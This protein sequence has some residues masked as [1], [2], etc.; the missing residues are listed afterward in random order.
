MKATSC[1]IGPNDD[2]VLPRGSQ[3]TDWEVEL[4]VVIGKP[5]KY[6]D[7]GG[8]AVARRRLL[9]HQRRLRARVSARGHGAVGEGQERRHVRPDRSVARHRRRGRRLRNLDL[10]LEVDGHR[11]QNGSTK[12]MVFGVPFL[13][14]YLS[15]FMSLQPGDIISTGTPPGVGHGQKPPV[16]LRAGN[17]DAPRGAGTR[18]AD[19]ASPRGVAAH[20]PSHGSSTLRIWLTAT[21]FRTCRAPLGQRTSIR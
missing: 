18:R 8:R 20:N 6:V 7:R 1:I 9:R 21:S 14:S 3:K 17:V 2:V 4:G 19:A 15:R 5:A 13:V 11:Y 10:W 16:Y 12:T